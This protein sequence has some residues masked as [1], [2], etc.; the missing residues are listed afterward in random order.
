VYGHFSRY[1]ATPGMVGSGSFE[2]KTIF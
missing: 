1:K 2:I